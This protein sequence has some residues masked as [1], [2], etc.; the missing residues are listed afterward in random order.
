MVKN[1]EEETILKPQHVATFAILAFCA[2]LVLVVLF[3]TFYIVS[4]GERAVLITL[5]NPSD[6][7]ISEGLH[8]KL[9][10]IQSKVI[11][12]IKTQKDEVEATSASKDLQTV[13]AKIAVNYHLEEAS[14][15]RIYKEVGV[16]YVNR[17]LS[18][19]IQE[20]TK[21]S[22]AQFTAEELI[23]KREQVR[24]KI[25]ELL[26]EKMSPRGIVVEDV[27]ITNFDFSKS[28][29]DAIEAKV[30]SQQNALKELNNL[31]AV[32]YQAQQRVTQA[33]GEAEAI[34]IQAA[35]ITSQGGKEYV[36]LQ[37]IAKWNGVVSQVS[38]G[39]TPF[40]NLDLNKGAETTT[41]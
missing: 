31:K 1:N 15:P 18:P 5:G 19:A 34:R 8:F 21:A 22:T 27:L 28:F 6:T 24:E 11:F 36:N 40:I 16:D 10:I 7:T 14:A 17:I 12:D 37:W 29:N 33:Q 39:A 23:T 26:R 13:N 9:P 4:A 35:A 20:S 3:G 38:G 2:L 30:T 25:R 41:V 32:E